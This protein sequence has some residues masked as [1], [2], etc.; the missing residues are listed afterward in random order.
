MSDFSKLVGIVDAT[1]IQVFRHVIAEVRDEERIPR[2]DPEYSQAMADA[3]LAVHGR[4]AFEVESLKEVA[5]SAV[6]RLLMEQ[7]IL[8]R[9]KEGGAGGCSR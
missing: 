9:G 5:R 1:D 3:I 8:D 2:N 4:M 6:R 7:A